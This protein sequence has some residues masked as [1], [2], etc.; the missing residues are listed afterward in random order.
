MIQVKNNFFLLNTA[1]TSYCFRI[2]PTGQLEHLYYG[3]S[4]PL[5]VNLYDLAKEPKFAPANS[6]S[7]D[8]DLPQYSPEALCLECSGAGK[9]DIREPFVDLIQTDGSYTTD[10]V[11]ESH[12]ISESPAPLFTLPCAYDETGTYRQLTLSLRDKNSGILLKLFYGILP[13]VDI[14]LRSA[15]LFNESDEPITLK[16]LASAQVDF[17]RSDFVV[18]SFHGHWA[19]EMNRYDTALSM[20]KFT[21]SSSTGTSSSRCNPLFLLHPADTTEE[22]GDCYGFNL[23]YSGNHREVIEA[24]FHEHTRVV[25]GINPKHFSFLLAPGES[26]EAPQAVLTYSPAGFGGVSGNFHSFVREHIVRGTWKKK[27]RPILLNSWEAFY[28]HFDEESLLDLAK[29]GKEAG[30]ELFVLDDGWFGVRN[31]DHRSLG[32]WTEN[33]EKLPS[34]MSG[35]A[36]KIHNLGLDFGL[37]IEPEMVNTDSEL[38][39]SHPQWVLEIPGKNHS[40]GRFQRILD[41][42]NPEVV[43]YMTE[44]LRH[45]LKSARISYIKWDMNR[46]FSDCFSQAL[47]ANRQG[48]V[49]HRYILGVYKMAK[50]LTEEFPDVLFEG[51]SA[52][53]NRFDLGMLCY[54][55]QIWASD[56]TDAISR[57]SIQNGYSYGYPLSTVSA[58]V[59]ICPNHQ[60]GRITPLAT[61][62]GVA[63]FG[64]LGYEYNFLRTTPEEFIQI[65]EQIALYKKLRELFF[66]G[67]FHRIPEKDRV[68][69]A[70]TSKD[71]SQGVLLFPETEKDAVP[72]PDAFLL[73]SMGLDP[74]G[75]YQVEDLTKSFSE[76][77]GETKDFSCRILYFQETS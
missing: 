28:F 2:L 69:W 75:T 71:L 66:F 12:E 30:I 20:G 42:S 50:T 40:E 64:L 19:A 37:W 11:Y 35:L 1:H 9:G 55:P 59:S 26:F 5:S 56:N 34:G 54:F 33:P 52:G 67:D 4:L 49:F 62:F 14:I 23:I 45:L 32:D 73:K 25:T 70:V 72:C 77:P 48:E 17:P 53:G 57:L 18:T 63:A 15:T 3:K 41:F 43:S 36:E 8:N 68:C 27:P 60:T 13:K 24:D 22:T 31:D 65:K 47:P 16:G 39:R 58:H 29:A 74:N 46:I 10:F 76:I 6:V 61:R 44:K 38:Y 7:Y 21:L 51:C